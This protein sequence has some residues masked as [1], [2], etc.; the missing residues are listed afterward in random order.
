MKNK[1]LTLID[2]YGIGQR[3]TLRIEKLLDMLERQEN[4]ISSYLVLPC[5]V[6]EPILNEIAHAF[7]TPSLQG[8]ILTKQDESINIAAALSISI[9][10][11]MAI[12]YI[13][14][15]QN[16]SNDIQKANSDTI[17]QF[18]TNNNRYNK[19]TLDNRLKNSNR[20]TDHLKEE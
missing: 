15:G 14:N 13:C 5:N 1:N 8:Y 18:I 11:A 19:I 6:Q 17:L 20:I 2:T 9:M 4:T 7:N 3:D 12:A 16:T 10:H